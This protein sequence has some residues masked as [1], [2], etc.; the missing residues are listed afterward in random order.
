MVGAW[1]SYTGTFLAWF[2]L[3]IML[4][5]GLPMLIAPMAWGRII[6]F[7][8]PDQTD[9]TV[10]FGRSLGV[11]ISGLALA[12][13]GASSFAPAQGVVMD[14][15]ILTAFLYVLTHVHGA[16]MR[17][18][19][20]IETLEIAFFSTLVLLMLAVYPVGGQSGLLRGW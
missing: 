1:S 2:P 13:Y 3:L 14:G 17:I 7:R 11:A 4:V 16:V 18:Q 9:L 8:L 20:L 19:P 5:F 10:Y 12:A 6:G 15:L